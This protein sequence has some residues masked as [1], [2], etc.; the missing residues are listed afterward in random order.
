MLFIFKIFWNTLSML[1]SPSKGI[2]KKFYCQKTE[3][4]DARG[5][6]VLRCLLCKRTIGG[7]NK[8]HCWTKQHCGHCH[9]LGKMGNP[10]HWD[11]LF[12]MNVVDQLNNMVSEVDQRYTV[13]QNVTKSVRQDQQL[14]GGESRCR[15]SHFVIDTP[16]LWVRDKNTQMTENIVQ[17]VM[18]GYHLTLLGVGVVA[19]HWELKVGLEKIE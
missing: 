7:K 4:R 6:Q 9:Y 19:I 16:R 5:S 10:Q 14:W 13:L 11:S 12:V 15:V 8:A 18:S 17:S 3:S 1:W 2:S